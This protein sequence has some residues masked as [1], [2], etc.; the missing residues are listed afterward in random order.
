M[1][2]TDTLCH[3]A[4]LPMRVPAPEAFEFMTD[5]DMMAQWS[6]GAWGLKPAGDGLFVGKSLFED[7]EVYC[8][9]KASRELLQLDYE[10]G[11]DPANLVPRIISRIIPGEHIGRGAGN[12]LVSLIAW[13]SE[14]VSDERWR[15]T[16][17]S[18]EA[19]IFRI[20]HLLESRYSTAPNSQ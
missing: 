11:E 9:L 3:T 10:V 2:L 4:T 19:E 7:L 15:M 20:R 12:C 5:T 13:R 17:V 14:A 16:C 1:N 6:F 18:H 8:R